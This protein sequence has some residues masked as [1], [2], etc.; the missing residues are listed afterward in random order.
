MCRYQVPKAVDLRQQVFAT[1]PLTPITRCDRVR[2]PTFEHP[3]FQ[4]TIFINTAGSCLRIKK[5]TCRRIR[6]GFDDNDILNSGLN[7]SLNIIKSRLSLT[8]GEQ[9]LQWDLST[10]NCFSVFYMQRRPP[11]ATACAATPAGIPPLRMDKMF[12]PNEC[13]FF[14]HLGFHHHGASQ[15]TSPHPLRPCRRIWPQS[16]TVQP[17]KLYPNTDTKARMGNTL[18]LSCPFIFLDETVEK[19]H[20]KFMPLLGQLASFRGHDPIFDLTEFDLEFTVSG[21]LF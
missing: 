1:Q 7:Q 8:D 19:G 4:R 14:E 15:C 16:S 12:V 10:L 11:F 3:T 21:V 2:V 9:K 5:D 18:H 20:H 17:Q 6:S 13:C